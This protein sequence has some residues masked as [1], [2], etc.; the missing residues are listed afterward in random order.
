MEK[1]IEYCFSQFIL[2]QKQD[3]ISIFFCYYSFQSFQLFSFQQQQNESEQQQ[4][5]WQQRAKNKTR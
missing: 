1:K 5:H 3:T 2:L 4:E